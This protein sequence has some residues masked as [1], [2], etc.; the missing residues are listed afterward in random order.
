MGEGYLKK[1]RNL[2]V[3][4]PDQPEPKR[5]L[6]TKTQRHQGFFIIKSFSLCLC[7][8]VAKN[9]LPEY[10]KI[11]A[12]GNQSFPGPWSEHRLKLHQN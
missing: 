12:I 6:A 9:I 4:N 1:E 3:H 10:G 2:P 8:F 5:K 7:V 11:I